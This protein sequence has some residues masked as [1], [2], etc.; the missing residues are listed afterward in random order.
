METLNE[1]I[2]KFV[3]NAPIS[4]QV[5]VTSVS[6]GITLDRYVFINLTGDIEIPDA[7]VEQELPPASTPDDSSTPANSGSTNGNSSSVAT[8]GCGG[9]CGGVVNAG[10][11]VFLLPFVYMAFR[12]RED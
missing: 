9:G 10:G 4:G 7:D 12:K 11:V 5:G 1:P 6:G 8:N 3:V 2:A